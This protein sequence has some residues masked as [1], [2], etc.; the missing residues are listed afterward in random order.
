MGASAFF[1]KAGALAH[2][3]AMLLIGYNKTEIVKYHAVLNK[4]VSSDYKISFSGS[5]PCKYFTLCF[6]RC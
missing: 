1:G 2:T 3:E 6:S 4:S 5:K